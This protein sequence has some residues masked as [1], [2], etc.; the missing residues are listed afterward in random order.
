MSTREMMSAAG[1]T[2][3]PAILVIRK[4]GFKVW[5]DSNTMDWYAESVTQR[6]IAEDPLY[7]LALISIREQRG[8]SWH[9]K[10]GEVEAVLAEFGH[11]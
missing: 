6:F 8:E 10:E 2:I 4:K 5:R 1:N 7:L 3:V 11:L 9:P